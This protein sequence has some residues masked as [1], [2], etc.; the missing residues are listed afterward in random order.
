MTIVM[1]L[2]SNQPAKFYLN[3]DASQCLN[4]IVVQYLH[5][6]LQYEVGLVQR[7]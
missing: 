6:S 5:T 2:D 3:F 7:S 4:Y 1:F